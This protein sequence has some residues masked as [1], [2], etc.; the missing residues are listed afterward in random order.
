MAV[1][2][3]IGALLGAGVGLGAESLLNKPKSPSDTAPD[4]PNT[5][6]ASAAAS[7]TVTSNRAALLASGGQTDETG[8]LGIL[9]G[10]DVATTSLIGG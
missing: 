7:N 8:G 5:S 10:S 9:N 1:D 4:V 2:I 3:I 6:N